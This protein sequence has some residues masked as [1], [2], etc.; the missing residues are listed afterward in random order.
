MTKFIDAA[1]NNHNYGY[2]NGLLTANE[3]ETI[4]YS[5]DGR[6]KKIAQSN[7][8]FVK[9]TYNDTATSADEETPGYI[10]AVTVSDS[11]GVTDVWYY[12]DGIY[13]S[14]PYGYSDE[15]CYLPNNIS[16]ELTFDTISNVSYMFYNFVCF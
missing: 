3:D 8:A 12:S 7:G 2:T 11:R 14:S 4:T 6:V 13:L 9:Y 1:N 5:A 10:G 15:A 16:N